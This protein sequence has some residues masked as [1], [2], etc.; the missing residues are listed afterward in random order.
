M[1]AGDGD[2]M[3]GFSLFTSLASSSEMLSKF[4]PSA[5]VPV[6]AMFSPASLRVLCHQSR[7]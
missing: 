3:M 2:M 7:G 6:M 4:R 1:S 5:T